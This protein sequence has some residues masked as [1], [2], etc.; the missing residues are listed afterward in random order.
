[1]VV[2]E[3]VEV[4]KALYKGFW[5]LL[6]C[7]YFRKERDGE[8]TIH[9]ITLHKSMFHYIALRYIT[10]HFA[11]H[12]TIQYN[13]INH[14]IQYNTIQYNIP[15]HILQYNTVQYNIPYHILQYNTVQYNTFPFFVRVYIE[16]YT[17]I[18]HKMISNCHLFHK[19]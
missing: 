3:T 2:S 14:T 5:I 6:F 17:R 10:L 18:F 19:I 9:C 13:T 15:Y 1:M 8:N 12:I 4:T 16:Y 7:Q 11:R